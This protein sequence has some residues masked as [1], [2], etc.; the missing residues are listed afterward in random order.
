MGGENQY[1]NFASTVA[2]FLVTCASQV[3]VLVSNLAE[4]EGGKEMKIYPGHRYTQ[5]QAGSI[6][7]DLR[8]A[9]VA[10]NGFLALATEESI[11]RPCYQPF[12]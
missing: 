9:E 3:Q 4:W 12:Y 11:L 10:V 1:H 7:A 6:F 2:S 5:T 8:P